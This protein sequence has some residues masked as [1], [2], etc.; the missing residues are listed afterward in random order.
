MLGIC[1]CVFMNSKASRCRTGEFG[2]Q[3]A[4]QGPKAKVAGNLA[5]LLGGGRQA[6]LLGMPG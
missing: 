3:R 4:L 6:W 2:M 1:L 5:R